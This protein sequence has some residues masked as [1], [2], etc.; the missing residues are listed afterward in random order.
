MSGDEKGQKNTKTYHCVEEEYLDT[1]D[2]DEY[3]SYRG[4]WIAIVGR[5]V[6]AHG[7]SISEVGKE[8]TKKANG[9]PPM[10]ERILRDDEDEIYIM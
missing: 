8:A 10:L 3:D 7:V 5:K 9:K 1:M 6:V 2:R 4:E